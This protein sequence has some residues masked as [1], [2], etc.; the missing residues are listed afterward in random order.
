MK[1]IFFFLVL[2]AAA[3]GQVNKNNDVQL[4]IGE[5]LTKKASSYCN[6]IF[7]NEWR[8]GNDITQLYHVYLQGL[9]DFK[10]HECFSMGPAYRQNW[11]R[12]DSK[13]R[14]VYEPFFETF[15]S[16]GRFF[17]FRNRIS[18]LMIESAPNFWQYRTRIQ[19]MGTWKFRSKALYP[20]VSGEFFVRSQM[21][22]SQMRFTAGM[23]IP[24]ME[25]FRGSFYYLLRYLNSD[26]HWTHQHIL[27]T[28]LRLNF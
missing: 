4:W 18:Y 16:K 12:F 13:W 17:Q 20:Y 22:L 24:F 14:E 23:S 11:I 2:G 15:F 7:T 6:A 10:L 9:L 27:G 1:R 21:G 3:W 28:W 19:F 8:I 5:E 26:P 25:N